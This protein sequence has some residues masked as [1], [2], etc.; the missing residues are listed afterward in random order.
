[1]DVIEVYV[2]EPYEVFP[3]KIV[4]QHVVRTQAGERIM[5]VIEADVEIVKST[6]HFAEFG[7][8]PFGEVKLADPYDH[9]AKF[10][11]PNELRKLGILLWDPPLQRGRTKVPECTIT[12]FAM[13]QVDGRWLAID[14][15]V[16]GH[17]T[18]V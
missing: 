6:L 14:G 15:F 16:Y 11:Y 3:S 2:D 12:Q 5:H 17:H 8:T 1:M 9:G 7:I 18:L 4:E 10:D 13:V